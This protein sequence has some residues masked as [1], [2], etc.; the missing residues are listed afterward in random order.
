MRYGG[1]CYNYC[2]LAHGFVDIVVEDGLKPYDIQPL[3]PIV[4]GAGGVVTDRA[5]ETPRGG[6]MVVA[7]ANADLH[8]RA[9]TAMAG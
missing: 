9:L 5:G 2:L 3:V 4:R 1:D 6:S 7:A 8:R